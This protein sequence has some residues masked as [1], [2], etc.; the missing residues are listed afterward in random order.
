[1]KRRLPWWVNPWGTVRWL[2]AAYKNQ[3]DAYVR[4][5]EKVRKLTDELR[6]VRAHRDDLLRR[7]EG[8][9]VAPGSALDLAT[10]ITPQFVLAGFGRGQAG[11]RLI[12]SRNLD[13][14]NLSMTDQS[15][16]PPRWALHAK[17]GKALI[18]DKPTYG[19]ALDHMSVIW[20]NW[21]QEGKTAVEQRKEIGP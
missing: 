18:I 5:V 12:A 2:Q 20:R 21:E 10:S 11:V 19:E 6:R 9:T 15:D 8:S 4:Q 7:L 13:G 14:T 16:P 17:L 3:A 1:V